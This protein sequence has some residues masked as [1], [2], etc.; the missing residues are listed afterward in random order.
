MTDKLNDQQGATPEFLT[1]KETAA[2]LR[3]TLPTLHNWTREGLIKSYK[4]GGRVLYNTT[5]VYG[6]LSLT[7][8]KG[9]W[10]K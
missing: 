5:E 4:L 3:I 6:S 7:E 8:S 2:K 10:Y 1:R 9:K